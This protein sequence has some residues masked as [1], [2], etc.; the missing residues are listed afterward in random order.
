MTPRVTVSTHWSQFEFSQQRHDMMMNDDD[1]TWQ[2]I[3]YSLYLM[4]NKA[5]KQNKTKHMQALFCLNIVYYINVYKISAVCCAWKDWN[6]Y[7][8]VKH[9]IPVLRKFSGNI[10]GKY[11]FGK[12]TSLFITDWWTGMTT[13]STWFC[14]KPIKFKLSSM[15]RSLLVRF[16]VIYYEALN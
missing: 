10:S 12:A 1:I 4:K 5:Q 15:S 14:F 16:Q 8:R 13:M 2:I 3:T 9:V 11:F 6:Y 7:L